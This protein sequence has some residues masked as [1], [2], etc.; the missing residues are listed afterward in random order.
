MPSAVENARTIRFGLFEV[1]LGAGEL[2]RRGVRIRLQ[3]QPFR[4]LEA[5]LEKPGRVVTRDELR[6]RLWPEDARTDLDQR[7]ATAVNKLREALGDSASNPS[8]VETVP[9]QGYRFLAAIG[10]DAPGDAAARRKPARLELAAPPPAPMST[11]VGRER[12]LAEAAGLLVDARLLTI[13][14]PGGAG[15]TRLAIELARKVQDR[16]SD[17][18]LFVPLASTASAAQ[19]MGDLGRALGLPT[20][21]PE[22]LLHQLHEALGRRRALLILDNFEHLLEAAGLVSDL[23]SRSASLKVLVTSR[24]PLRLLG[25][26]EYPL[27]PLTAPSLDARS[28]ESLQGNPAVQLF[29]DRA[30]A[31]D[32]DFRVDLNNASAVARLCHGLDG[33]PLAIELAAARVRL[34]SPAALADRLCRRLEVLGGGNRDLP[35][36]QRTLRRAIEWSYDLLSEPARAVLRRLAVFDGGMTLDAAQALCSGLADCE[37]DALDA[38]TSLSDQNMVQRCSGPDEEVRFTMLE[39]IRAFGLDRLAAEGEG[40]QVRRLHAEYFLRVAQEAQPHLTGPRQGEWFDR[41]DADHA[42]FRAALEWAGAPQGEP[43]LGVRLGAALWRYWIVRGRLYEGRPLLEAL[44]ARPADGQ[45]VEPRMDALYAIGSLCHYQGELDQARSALSECVDLARGTSDLRRQAAALS[46]LGWVHCLTSEFDACLELSEQAR[47]LFDQVGDPRGAAVALNNCG[48]A[49]NY[50]GDYPAGR[51]YHERSLALRREIG[52]VR[53][54]GFTLATWAWA[55]RQRGDYDRAEELLAESEATLAP[56]DDK[57]LSGWALIQRA[58]L[59]RSRGRLPEAAG[60]LIDALTRWGAGGHRALLAW[61]QGVLGG[62]LLDWGEPERGRELLADALELWQVLRCP[63]AVAWLRFE[64]GRWMVDRQPHQARRLLGE[65][66]EIRVRIGDRR[67]V[68][69]CLETLLEAE[70]AALAPTDWLRIHNLTQCLRDRLQCPAAP[71]VE[72]R[73]AVRRQG[74]LAQVAEPLPEGPVDDSDAIA[75]AVERLQGLRG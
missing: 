2:R 7:L 1:N 72:Q 5:L 17:G 10:G 25:E 37:L 68:A 15:K 58:Q 45:P 54:I 56:I 12:E 33:L 71:A 63:W 11:F 57:V 42:N 43:L 26:Q 9:R 3:E 61:T 51:S 73:L 53:G 36:R 8:Y 74:A 50:C 34:F 14:G 46:G 69:E 41:L 59:A 20:A 60:L 67:G 70:R 44:L 13:T 4:I 18:V 27:E 62:V 19:V 52:D 40:P 29:V 22:Q 48:W 66:L 23:L 16:F 24:A 31:V 38:L 6:R 28:P 30:Q 49:A 32:P 75:W 55:E 65:S 47:Q 35:E 39:S 21:A 64:Q